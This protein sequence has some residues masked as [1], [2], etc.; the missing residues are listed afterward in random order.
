MDTSGTQN[1]ISP[2]ITGQTSSVTYGGIYT[3]RDG[4]GDQRGL[5]FQVYTANVGL[6]IGMTIKS[7]KIINLSNV[8]T[9]S[10]GLVSGD[11]YQ[12]AGVLNIVH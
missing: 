7:S 3:K 4:P 2:I 5:I 12:T 1:V 9:T 11:I 10:A 6:N 8:P